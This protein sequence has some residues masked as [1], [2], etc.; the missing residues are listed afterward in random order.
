MSLSVHNRPLAHTAAEGHPRAAILQ[1]AVVGAAAAAL[2][3]CHLGQAQSGVSSRSTNSKGTCLPVAT[4]LRDGIS[5]G[6]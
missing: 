4:G 5:S 6:A 2:L 1:C 3:P